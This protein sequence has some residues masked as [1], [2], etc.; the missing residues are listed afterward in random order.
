MKLLEKEIKELLKHRRSIN[1]ALRLRKAI[2]IL[3]HGALYLNYT[4]GEDKYGCLCKINRA[5]KKYNLSTPTLEL[6]IGSMVQEGGCKCHSTDGRVETYRYWWEGL[7]TS[8]P[9]MDL[10]KNRKHFDIKVCMPKVQEPEFGLDVTEDYYKG[11]QPKSRY[12]NTPQLGVRKEEEA[13]RKTSDL[14][15]KVGFL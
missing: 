10:I 4:S 1:D 7:Q 6:K 9:M 5:I 8:I 14:L 2:I 11:G 13:V 15:R 3:K 12:S